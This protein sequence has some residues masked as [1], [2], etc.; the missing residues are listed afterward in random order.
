MSFANPI[1]LYLALAVFVLTLFAFAR[2]QQ[3]KRRILVCFVSAEMLP[4][5]LSSQ[6]VFKLR[7]KALMFA[8][9]LAALF[10]ALARPQYGY[11]LEEEKSYGVDIIFALDTSKSMLAED[12]KPNRLERSKLAIADLVERLES[13][14]VGLVAFSGEA[15][16]QCPL[17]LDYDAFRLSLEALDTDIIQRGGTNIA[18]AISEAESAFSK[19]KNQKILIL[20][21]D[22]EELEASAQP[23]AQKAFKDADI[24]IYTLGVGGANGEPIPVRDAKGRLDYLRDKD[25]KLVSSRLN[26][27]LLTQIAESAGGFYTPIASDGMDLIYEDGIRKN[28]KSEFASKMKKKPIERFQIPLALALILLALESVTGTRRLFG[29]RGGSLAM[30]ALMPLAGIYPNN[31]NAEEPL[32]N[33]RDNFN[34]GVDFYNAKDFGKAKENFFKSIAVSR[35]LREHA[36]AFY[37]AGAADYETAKLAAAN[38]QSVRDALGNSQNA[39]AQA[40]QNFA[41]GAQTLAQGLDVLKTSGEEALKSQELQNQIKQAISENESS[42]KS[43]EELPKANKDATALAGNL[44]AITD[45]ALKNF[46]NAIELDPEMPRATQATKSAKKAKEKLDA[47]SKEFKDIDAASKEH[48]ERISKLIEELKKLLRDEDN[49]QN[50]DQ[51]QQDNQDKPEQNKDEQKQDNSE[52]N[53]SDD[54]QDS[55]AQNQDSNNQNNQQDSSE[56]Q[57]QDEQKS[58]QEKSDKQE[59]DNDENQKQDEQAVA[60]EEKQETNGKN[61]ELPQPEQSDKK[62]E[63]ATSP[64]ATQDAALKDPQ[65]ASLEPGAETPESNQDFRAAE[66]A[67]T[68]REAGQVLDSLKDSEKKLPFSGYGTQKRRYEDKNYKDW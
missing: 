26:E 37:N 39:L 3:I 20:I 5:L 67:M 64:E 29:R 19:T 60:P 43:L 4:S 34:E 56:N 31:A 16:L 41:S 63:Q 10:V 9:G 57:N 1:F 44:S 18:A 54:K 42:K 28:E 22:G 66:G 21:S 8:L 62:E 33:W 53:K 30:L 48:T 12:V 24:K 68:K 25:G 35:D 49:Q 55:Q 65:P 6:S 51:Q 27:E 2:I 17:T 58:D 46:E 7:A 59:S 52:Q 13:D 14:R 40:E 23:R 45:G 11:T 50:Q 61:S 47:I 36:K 38:I 15:F 32:K